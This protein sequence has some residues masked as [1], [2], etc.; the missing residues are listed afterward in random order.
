MKKLRITLKGLTPLL[1][2]SCEGVNPLHPITKE[3]KKYT[4]KRQKTEEDLSTIS[5]LEWENGLYYN[6]EVGV[7]IPAEC[8]E[9]SFING[10]KP[11]KKGSD[12]QKYC[13]VVDM[14]IPL[15]YGCNKSKDDLK[16]DMS[17]RDVRAVNVQRAKV[18]RTRPRFNNWKITFTYVYDETKI[19]L[20][21]I[22]QSIEYA[23]SYI[24]LCDYR[25]RYGKF[26]AL[27]EEI[28]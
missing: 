27:V 4:S 21:T 25:P 8:V 23:G 3:L 12:I 28:D 13:N 7:Y 24:G 6:D 15:D 16:K 1:M 19:D 14:C 20:D 26:S 5:D 10:A 9:A 22:V 11:N 18:V 2:H 17:Y